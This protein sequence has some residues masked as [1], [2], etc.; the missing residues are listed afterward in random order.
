MSGGLQQTAH[1][2]RQGK[3]PI[4][5]GMYYFCTKLLHGVKRILW[6]VFTFA[7]VSLY[8]CV[9]YYMLIY[10]QHSEDPPPPPQV[11]LQF[12]EE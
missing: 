2:I 5:K 3:R 12:D 6:Y 10:Q 9:P 11:L 1:H 7:Q 8:D 4:E